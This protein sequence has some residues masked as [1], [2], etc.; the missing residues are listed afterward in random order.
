MKSQKT[1]RYE[2]FNDF[3]PFNLFILLHYLN[4]IL[5]QNEL[6]GMQL[7]D[8]VR[9]RI[10]T[11]MPFV[12]PS[13]KFSISCQPPT[14]PLSAHRLL[15]P[16]VP[17]PG[18]HP[19]SLRNNQVSSSRSNGPSKPTKPVSS[20]PDSDME[21]DPWTLLEDGAGSGP[22]SINAATIAGNDNANLKASSWLKGAV[23]VRRMDLTYIGAIDDDS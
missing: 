1:C 4:F 19:G 23:R 3:S 2:L 16:S 18:P 7:P 14:V 22:S 9:W 20:Q 11:A 13:L 12:F 21:I 17:I 6:D 5:L 8:A 15:Q 10:Q